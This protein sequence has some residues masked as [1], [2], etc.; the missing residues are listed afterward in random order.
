MLS[1]AIM[2]LSADNKAYQ[3][4]TYRV[5][6]SAAIIVLSANEKTL[7]ADNKTIAVAL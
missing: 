3:L 1:A 7:S 5:V 4:T 6:L 2:V